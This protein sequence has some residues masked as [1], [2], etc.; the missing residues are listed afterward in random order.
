MISSLLGPFGVALLVPVFLLAVV[1]RSWREYRGHG[2]LAA[3]I[4]A[5][6]IALGGTAWCLSR[7][8]LPSEPFVSAELVPG[9]SALHVPASLDRLSL[10]VQGELPDLEKA[11]SEMALWTL[12]FRSEGQEISRHQGSFSEKKVSRSFGRGLRVGS[13]ET[14]LEERVDVPSEVRG[15]PFDVV[16][17]EASGPVL[18][19]L[20]VDV[21]PALPP[22]GLMVAVGAL[23][24][25][26]GGSI[27]AREGRKGLLAL[28]FAV[29][30]FYA[31]LI[32]HG[33]TP[34]ATS[35]V[36]VPAILF[37]LMA[38]VPTGW[39]VTKVV[40]RLVPRRVAAPG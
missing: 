29:M 5:A 3:S 2:T 30:S 22:S 39:F 21:V 31:N 37:S 15:K 16:L 24:V 12:V 28:I 20:E 6:V 14:R 7:A 38:G 19:A 26:V 1:A 13:V 4:V 35:G 34:H 9:Q 40:R 11:S 32:S 33:A 23:L 27:D 25:A 17:G 10:L 18:G 36:V 8:M